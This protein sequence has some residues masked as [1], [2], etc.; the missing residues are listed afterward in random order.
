[1]R[2]FFVVQILN[3]Q[4]TMLLTWP[5]L[6]L[7]RVNSNILRDIPFHLN[8]TYVR[9]PLL[10]EISALFGSYPLHKGSRS[11]NLIPVENSKTHTKDDRLVW[12]STLLKSRCSFMFDLFG[13]DLGN[14][15]SSTV[16]GSPTRKMNEKSEQIHPLRGLNCS[17]RLLFSF[18][19]LTPSCD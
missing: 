9:R 6:Y 14:T 2:I 5:Q 8:P 18:N 7:A 19:P 15:G 1:M 13:G 3:L 17:G 10:S 11:V 4:I 12:E 16:G